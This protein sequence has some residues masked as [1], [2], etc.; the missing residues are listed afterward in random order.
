MAGLYPAKLSAKPESWRLFSIR[1]ADPAFQTFSN[2]VFERDQY[3]CNFCGFQARQ[4][5]EVVNLDGNYHNNKLSNLVTACCFC[6]QCFFL[7]AVGKS[8]YGGG[9]LVY[10]PEISQGDL[11][12]FCHV[13]FCA[14]ANATSYRIDAQSIYRGLISRSQVVE[15]QLGEGMSDPAL[16]GRMLIDVPD[17]DRTKI[18]EEILMP[19]RL[20]PSNTKFAKQV[21][22]WSQESLEELATE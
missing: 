7:E 21:D 10:L 8:D 22:A 12:G 1:K 19:L 11:N 5:Q 16:L 20:L 14:T 15:K 13:L 3:T 17:K 18:W 9:V 2:Q 4:Y 6:S